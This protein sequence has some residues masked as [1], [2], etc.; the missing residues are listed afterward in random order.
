MNKIVSQDY[1]LGFTLINSLEFCFSHL[2][3]INTKL[4]LSPSPKSQNKIGILEIDGLFF[5]LML[6]LQMHPATYISLN[7]ENP[8]LGSLD[9]GFQHCPFPEHAPFT[10]PLSQVPLSLLHSKIQSHG[11]CLSPPRHKTCWGFLQDFLFLLT[12]G[13]STGISKIRVMGKLQSYWRFF[14]LKDRCL[15]SWFLTSFTGDEIFHFTR[16]VIPAFPSF[17][18][19]QN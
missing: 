8:G 2:C 14:S 15:G 9:L 13:K 11:F 4:S 12:I 17:C 1:S 5:M 19:P 10:G 16:S 18:S 6:W 7:Q 3:I